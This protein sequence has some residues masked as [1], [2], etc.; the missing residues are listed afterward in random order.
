[1]IKRRLHWRKMLIVFH[2]VNK[3]LSQELKRILNDTYCDANFSDSAT[4][5][6]S[7]SQ[8]LE[9]LLRSLFIGMGSYCQVLETLRESIS[10]GLTTTGSTDFTLTGDNFPYWSSHTGE[11]HSVLFKVPQFSDSMKGIILCVVY[12][13]TAGQM[14]DKWQTIVL[15]VY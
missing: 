1:M 7:T 9:N 11:G 10:K 13:S 6:A 4:S 8:M 12:S 3:L 15:Q 5:Y 2:D 14:A